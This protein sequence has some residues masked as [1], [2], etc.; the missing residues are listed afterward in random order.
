MSGNQTIFRQSVPRFH[1]TAV[2][3]FATND[4]ARVIHVCPADAERSFRNFAA[5]LETARRQAAVGRKAR[6]RMETGNAPS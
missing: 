6:T 1:I 5:E 2:A 3:G 4:A